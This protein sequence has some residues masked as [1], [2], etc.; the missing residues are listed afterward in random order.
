MLLGILF[1]SEIYDLDLDAD[2]IFESHAFTGRN[3]LQAKRGLV[4]A[5]FIYL[6]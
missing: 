6:N 1:G 3:L 4:F 5:D 2:D